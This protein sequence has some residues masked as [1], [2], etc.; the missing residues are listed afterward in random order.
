MQQESLSEI[1]AKNPQH[2]L[3]QLKQY[4]LSRVKEYRD[5]NFN[6]LIHIT[7]NALIKQIVDG[8]KANKKKDSAQL[9][10]DYKPLLEYLVTQVGININ[11]LND[12]YSSPL[13][14]VYRMYACPDESSL[15]SE[16]FRLFVVNNDLANQL[17]PLEQYLINLGADNNTWFFDWGP[18]IRN[19]KKLCWKLL[20]CEC[21]KKKHN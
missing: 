5:K 18:E 1:I 15:T 20:C 6:N 2:A 12:N 11:E 7:V 16:S 3:E 17:K 13:I 19:V 9:I 4:R 14:L 8:K 10:L 21:M